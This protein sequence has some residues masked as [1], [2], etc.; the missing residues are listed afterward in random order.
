M[1]TNAITDS[2]TLVG[3]LGPYVALFTVSILRA[4]GL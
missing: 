4:W 2:F 3:I 1:H